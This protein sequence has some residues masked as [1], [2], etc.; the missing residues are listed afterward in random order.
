MKAADE[1]DLL[2]IWAGKLGEEDGLGSDHECDLSGEWCDRPS[3]Q[4]V[5]HAIYAV[6][7][8][9]NRYD[10]AEQDLLDTYEESYNLAQK[11]GVIA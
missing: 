6:A 10:D 3:S 2:D 11:Y 8:V 1:L 5:L 4:D 9:G 7:Q